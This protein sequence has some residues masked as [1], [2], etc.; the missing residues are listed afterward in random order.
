MN[1][2]EFV[3]EL[4]NEHLIQGSDAKKLYEM[5][6]DQIRKQLLSGQEVRIDGVCSLYLKYK[7][8]GKVNNNL[9]GE[10]NVVGA[11]YRLKCN[12]FPSMQKSLN[13]LANEVA[14]QGK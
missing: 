2:R 11:R 6:C 9:T 4:V 13:K 3:R 14:K 1:K 12:T 8:P 7:K 5:V 10:Q